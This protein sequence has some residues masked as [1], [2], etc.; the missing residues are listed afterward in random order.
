M[1]VLL[2]YS[3]GGG[4]IPI[5]PLEKGVP[6]YTEAGSRHE[7]VATER[8][9]QYGRVTE[10]SKSYFQL[11]CKRNT[12]LA[13]FQLNERVLVEVLVWTK[14]KVQKY[15]MPTADRKDECKTLALAPDGTV[16]DLTIYLQLISEPDKEGE[17]FPL[18][19]AARKASLITED[20]VYCDL[21]ADEPTPGDPITAR[22]IEIGTGNKSGYLKK[23]A[24]KLEAQMKP[25]KQK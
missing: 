3:G 1:P 14:D 16:Y 23:F 5:M 20:S 9:K 4:K 19:K 18:V 2:T 11:A 21:H 25:F 22:T 8:E 15:L 12:F 6:P 24:D 7:R 13:D 17:R 10:I